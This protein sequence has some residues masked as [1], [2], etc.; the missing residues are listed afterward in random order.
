MTV[1]PQDQFDQRILELI[2]EERA[3]AGLNSVYLSERLDAAADL[4]SKQMAEQDF[5]DHINPVTA[6]TPEA[7]AIAE[8]YQYIELGE[9]IGSGFSTP[10]SIM[11]AWI[12][13]AKHRANILDPNFT[14]LGLGY[15]YLE[16]DTGNINDRTYWTQLFGRGG[17]PGIYVPEEEP[18]S[19]IDNVL[20]GTSV[21]EVLGGGV[22][23]DLIRGLGGNDT[24]KGQNNEDTLDG[25]AGADLLL[26]GNDNDKLIGHVNND[27]LK[28]GSGDD[29]I[30]GV[31][32]SA[33]KAIVGRNEKDVLIG[34]GG[35]D[36][37]F[38]GRNGKVYYNDG[39]NSTVG[40]N[41]YGL[42]R[43]FKVSEGDRVALEGKR[44]DY[45]L[46]TSVSNVPNGTQIFLKNAQGPNE[47]IGIIQNVNVT[48]TNH[49][50]FKYV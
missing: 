50:M 6:S 49:S 20:E 18:T 43:G 23:P 15:Y 26:G 9:N 12:N 32:P 25:G 4:H 31:N 24:L 19:D 46:G 17:A 1:L 10:E 44:T 40:K 11:E 29:E 34:N 48:N 8:G 21:G 47:L 35:A 42:I 3:A 14:H 37:F 28:G 45:V 7:R 33:G 16:N 39:N 27:T 36:T 38:L 5:F 2:N 22:N 13:S 30:I 41:D